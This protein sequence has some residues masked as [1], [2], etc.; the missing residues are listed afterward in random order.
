MIHSVNSSARWR[1]AEEHE[2]DRAEEDQVAEADHRVAVLRARH[3]AE[4]RAAS[5][6]PA[7]S[8]QPGQ[9]TWARCRSE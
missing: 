4:Q 6:E 9:P 8:A 1:A 3:A 7:A 2:P 5:A